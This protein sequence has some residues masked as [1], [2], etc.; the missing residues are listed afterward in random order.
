MRFYDE[1]PKIQ[2]SQLKMYR[3]LYYCILYIHVYY[4]YYCRVLSVWG[5]YKK[6]LRDSQRVRLL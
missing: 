2:V 1:Q 4:V 3:S 5:G 6:I